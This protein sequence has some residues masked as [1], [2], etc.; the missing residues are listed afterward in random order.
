MERKLA[1]MQRILVPGKT[2]QVG[3]ELQSALAPQWQNAL[4]LFGEEPGARN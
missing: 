4:D 1:L 3:W 2:G